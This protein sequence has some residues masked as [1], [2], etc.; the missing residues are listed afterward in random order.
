M[1][2]DAAILNCNYESTSNSD[3]GNVYE[4]KAELLQLDQNDTIVKSIT[5]ICE[6][7]KDKSSVNQLKIQNQNLTKV[8][9]E[10]ES[11]FS[12]LKSLII[13]NTSITAVRNENLRNFTNLVYLDLSSNQIHEIS[14]DVFSNN[15]K[16]KFIY[17]KSNFLNSISIRTFDGLTSLKTIDLRNNSDVNYYAATESEVLF[18]KEQIFAA[19]ML[20][21]FENLDRRM[22]KL[23]KKDDFDSKIQVDAMRNNLRF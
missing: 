6:R 10:I 12:N 16:L 2:I 15:Q 14:S 23:E 20:K 1:L 5:K 19:N 22:E 9:S 11:F 21:L 8:P 4:C 7:Y 18:L 17:L 13:T 3:L